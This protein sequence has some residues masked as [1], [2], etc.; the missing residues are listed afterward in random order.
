[1]LTASSQVSGFGFSGIR[2]RHFQDHP[3]R[4]SSH[5]LSGGSTTAPEADG[6]DNALDE[7]AAEEKDELL[8][9]VQ[10]IGDKIK[11]L[12]TCRPHITPPRDIEA[13]TLDIHPP[14]EDIQSYIMAQ[15]KKNR[16]LARFTQD[17]ALRDKILESITSKAAGMFLFVKL[18]MDLLG[19]VL[20]KDALL[21]ALN[22]LPAD[23]DT[24][25][26]KTLEQIKHEK[27]ELQNLGLSA[28]SWVAFAKR[29]LTVQELQAAL[30]IPETK[31]LMPDE[32]SLVEV[33]D[34]LEAC[35]GLL[36]VDKSKTGQLFHLVHY[37]TQEFMDSIQQEEFPDIHITISKTLLVSLQWAHESG[38]FPKDDYTWFAPI[39]IKVHPLLEYSQY[40][41][42]HVKGEPELRLKIEL[43]SGVHNIK[44]YPTWNVH[45]WNF[46]EQPK[47]LKALWIAVVA[48]LNHLVEWL[49]EL[50]NLAQIEEAGNLVITAT[51]CGHLR[52]LELFK[53]ATITPSQKQLNTAL[54]KAVLQN[55][56]PMVKFLIAWGSDVNSIP[57]DE[58]ML[59]AAARKNY[60]EL[61]AAYK[62]D[63]KIIQLLL[64]STADCNVIGGQYGTALQA[65]SALG[66]EDII[67][68]LLAANADTN[69]LA[70]T[71]GTALQAAALG[72]YE[73]CIQFLLKANADPNLT[74]GEYGSAVQAA[75]WAGHQNIV[76]LLI[77]VNHNINLATG[78][79]GSALQAASYKGHQDIVQLLLQANAAPNQV[80][81]DGGTAL[82]DAAFEGFEEIVHM[83]LEANADPN[84]VGG[85]HGTPLQAAA[86]SGHWP[87][88]EVLLKAQAKP[89][90]ISKKHGTALQAAAYEGNHDAVQLLLQEDAD[91]NLVGG[92]YGTALQT[93]VLKGYLN[94]VPLLLAANANPNLVIENQ[95]HSPQQA[96]ADP[97]VY[98]I[99]HWTP[100][101]IAAYQGHIEIAAL[102]LQA[103]ANPNLL[104]TQYGS[105]LQAAAYQE[106][107]QIIQLLLQHGA[108]INLKGGIYGTALQ[109][110]A[111]KGA[112]EIVQLLLKKNADP[113]I[114]GG[115]YGTSFQA[116]RLNEHH[117]I[118]HCLLEAG[119]DPNH[120]S[121]YEGFIPDQQDTGDL[122]TVSIQ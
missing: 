46:M 83:L 42:A 72:G 5:S 37:S 57:S 53:A 50:D 35:H 108:D 98:G 13:A 90:T 76:Q 75:A 79:Y 96:N 7:Y 73:T 20:T 34:L 51:S 54:E 94:I 2:R 43:L 9:L 11:L 47:T 52:Q 112:L 17:Q 103:N 45:P 40:L 30:A 15:I 109:A 113:N 21:K 120:A 32:N 23:L 44:R 102:L 61:A 41:L 33:E 118:T 49:L 82:Q 67:Q 8:D 87:I 60:Q 86:L 85:D 25:Y 62:G 110:A 12:V 58:T 106:K 119:A 16:R 80:T 114:I 3:T 91:P 36:I 29:P 88:V 74:G 48:D 64:Q 115:K 84:L 1:M 99:C 31:P 56:I 69:I 117:E 39:D 55:Q 18:Q 19:S 24:L 89:N 77:D 101:Y 95:D 97:E 71:Y 65:A 92:I 104:G 70:G 63:Q 78:K 81:E 66:Y 93:A 59:H 105:A 26:A 14:K 28:L 10:G 38:D 100:L 27:A 22:S 4:N 6:D 107:S 122:S 121:D 68:I 111:S 116:A